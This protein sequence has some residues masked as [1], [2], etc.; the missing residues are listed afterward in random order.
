MC[1][2]EQD[3]ILEDRAHRSRFLSTNRMYAPF[4]F[5]PLLGVSIDRCFLVGYAK[6]VYLHCPFFVFYGEWHVCRQVICGLTLVILTTLFKLQ[7]DPLLSLIL[8][9]A[10]VF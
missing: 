10:T 4:C 5:L 9:W 1:I 8:H 7:Q 3:E 6:W 2:F